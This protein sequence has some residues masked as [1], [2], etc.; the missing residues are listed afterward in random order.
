MAFVSVP[1]C[2]ARVQVVSQARGGTDASESDL[3]SPDLSLSIPMPEDTVALPK[4]DMMAEAIKQRRAMY[5]AGLLKMLRDK[6]LVGGARD[7]RNATFAIEALQVT[8]PTRSFW[9]TASGFLMPS[10]RTP[11]KQARSRCNCLAKLINRSNC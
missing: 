3:F 7:M 11:M 8:S 2:R 9:Y 4:A 5:Q 1:G 6:D 10:H